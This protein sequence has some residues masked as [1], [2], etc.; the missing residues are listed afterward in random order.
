LGVKL[1]MVMGHTNC[2]AVGVLAD[3]KGGPLPD[4]LYIFQQLMC[5]LVDGNAKKPNESEPAYRD[6]LSRAN[7]VRQ[8]QVVYDRSRA[9]REQVDSGKIW[10]VPA[11]YDLA[12]G[13]A[14]FFKLVGSRA[15]A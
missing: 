13:K 14:S 8:A 4:N 11:M 5:G 15:K 1:V 6:R 3:A 12:A 10:L 9:V 7:A 2:G